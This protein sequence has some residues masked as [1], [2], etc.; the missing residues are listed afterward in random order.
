MPLLLGNAKGILNLQEQLRHAGIYCT[1]AIDVFLATKIVLMFAP[2]LIGAYLGFA[3]VMS[4]T[5]GIELGVMIGGVAMM[6]PTV[7]LKDKKSKRQ[8]KLRR[9]LPD[10]L[11]L[12]V[13]CLE[14]GLTI[15]SAIKR[16]S[17]ELKSLHASFA[18]ELELV[19]ND[20][21]LGYSVGEAL[22]RFAD[23]CDLQDIRVLAN[24]VSQSHRFGTSIGTAMRVQ[25]DSI[26]ENRR[27][28]AEES[29]R[30]A[31]TKMLIPTILFIFPGILLV[32]M[33]PALSAILS[34]IWGL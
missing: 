26:R 15:E 21:K 5:H 16:I 32:V 28:K 6:L 18:E 22:R 11:D 24:V 4:L 13:V 14:C 30:Q 10:A 20:A 25:A 2:I 19:A 31:G 34:T 7:Y 17:R 33:G 23:R 12:I 29:A 1:R 27:L 3:G 9:S 8:R